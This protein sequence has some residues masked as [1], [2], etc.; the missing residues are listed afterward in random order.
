MMAHDAA[1]MRPKNA[2]TGSPIPF[3]SSRPVG[4]TEDVDVHGQAG[5][6]E[7]TSFSRPFFAL[8]RRVY[9]QQWAPCRQFSLRG[10]LN[11][12]TVVPPM[13]I[14]VILARISGPFF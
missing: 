11:K 5:R 8:I 4:T 13:T 6:N 10:G 14:A 2:R 1:G 12:K 7:M 9:G 3:A